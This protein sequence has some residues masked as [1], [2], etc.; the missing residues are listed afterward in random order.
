MRTLTVL[1]WNTLRAGR[2]G[3]SDRRARVQI[4][5]INALQPDVFLMQEANGLDAHDSGSLRALGARIGMHGLLAIAPRS[6][7]H[8]ALFLRAPVNAL[9]FEMDSANFH[10]ALAMA[11]VELPPSSSSLTVI[12]THLSPCSAAARRREA[13]V[14][15]ARAAPDGLAVLAGDLNSLSPHDPDPPDLDELAPQHRVRYLD[16]ESS[17][18]DRS[19]LTQ[20]EAAGWVDVVHALGGGGTPTVPAA[21]FAETEFPTM[22]CDYVLASTALAA[23]ALSYEVPR[24]AATDSASDHYP[25]LVRFAAPG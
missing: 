10:H 2:D 14:L 25:L 6:G 8:L 4:D 20:L 18:L 23:R 24:T 15:A 17:T 11:T 12:N 7:Y 16:D 13:A 21:G 3:G 5:V 22:R 19:V 9:S 1:T